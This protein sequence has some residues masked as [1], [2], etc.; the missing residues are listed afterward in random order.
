MDDENKTFHKYGHQSNLPGISHVQDY[1]IS[2]IGIQP[3]PGAS[4]NG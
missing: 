4:A 2:K 1:G 3:I